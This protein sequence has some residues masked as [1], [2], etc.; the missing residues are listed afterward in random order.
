MHGRGAHRCPTG[1]N[2]SRK[3]RRRRLCTGAAARGLCFWARAK[4]AQCRGGVPARGRE[5]AYPHPSPPAKTNEGAMRSG[6]TGAWTARRPRER[7]GTPSKDLP[8]TVWA[9]PQLLDLA[10]VGTVW[11]GPLTGSVLI[12]PRTGSS[13]RPTSAPAPPR[14]SPR[15]HGRALPS[16]ARKRQ[17]S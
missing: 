1:C 3:P 8:F 10:R 4:R 5:G 6:G 16:C 15:P 2:K 14:T 11:Y 12:H 17:V 13:R 7:L 9:T